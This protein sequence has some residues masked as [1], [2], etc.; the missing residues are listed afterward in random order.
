MKKKISSIAFVLAGTFSLLLFLSNR[1]EEQEVQVD[2][3]ANDRKSIVEIEETNDAIVWVSP[4]RAEE[5]MAKTP[6]KVFIDVY[7]DWCGWCHKMEKTSFQDPKVI[8]IIN[9]DYYAI[10]FNA[11][12]KEEINFD[13][14]TY[15]SQGKYNTFAA[16]LLNGKM[17][18]PSIVYLGTNKKLITV[19]KGYRPSNDLLVDLNFI[20]EE[21]YKT[22]TYDAYKKGFSK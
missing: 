6:K 3:V 20:K 17:S 18:F 2:M 19:V 8:S 14:Q 1:Y 15:N 4:E 7:T 22:T 9:K 10:R 12:S 5:L 21:A 11:E 16:S 13:G